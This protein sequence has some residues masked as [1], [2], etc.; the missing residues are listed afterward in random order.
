MVARKPKP[1]AVTVTSGVEGQTVSVINRT[2]SEKLQANLDSSGRAVVDIQ[3]MPTEY[4]SGDVI[5]VIVGGEKMGSA[6]VTGSGDK[7]QKVTVATSSIA[8]GQ[9]RGIK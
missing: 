2:N 1:I 6:S 4:A 8:A 3:N 5:D 7:G 9:A